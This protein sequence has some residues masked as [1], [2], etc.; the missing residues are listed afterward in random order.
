MKR[1]KRTARLNYL[2]VIAFL[3]AI[4]LTS[5]YIR[6]GEGG[7]LH[8]L[9]YSFLDA[10]SG[11]L[12]YLKG[13][14][15]SASDWFSGILW[16]SKLKEE[17]E[18]LRQ[19]LKTVR[20]LI[21]ESEAV[22]RENEQLRQILG[23][24]KLYKEQA[25]AAEI[26]AVNQELSGKFYLVDKGRKDG[27][28]PNLAVITPDGVFGKVFSAG[29]NSSVI[30]P[31]NHPLSAVSAKIS[32]T[33]EFGIVEGSTSGRLYLK[34]IPKDSRATIGMIVVT[35][36]FG[37]VYPKNLLIGTIKSLKEDPNRLDL[38]IEVGPAVSFDTSDFVLILKET[39]DGKN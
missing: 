26:I 20:R 27:V 5:I 29:E 14:Y 9:K 25:I 12:S 7:V 16:S 23:L 3:I 32:E 13:K 21:L 30:I 28:K 39:K 38:V 33:G 11:T 18:K 10:V 2:L 34:M 24:K 19:E 37:G 8:N 36:G 15:N 6:E 31:I 22:K 17:N 1:R 4:L 35:S